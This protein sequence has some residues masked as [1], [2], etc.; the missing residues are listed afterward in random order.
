MRYQLNKKEYVIQNYEKKFK[1]I[2]PVLRKYMSVDDEVEELIKGFNIEITQNQTITNVVEDNEKLVNQV[3]TAKVRVAEL[4]TRLAEIGE[5]RHTTREIKLHQ[6]ELQ[7][8]CST[9]AENTQKI[10]K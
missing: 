9:K 2:I 10:I 6:A 1:R 8:S 3:Q 5:G 7:Q 4:E